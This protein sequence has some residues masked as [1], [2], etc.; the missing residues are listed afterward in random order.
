M[1]YLM[2]MVYM[3]VVCT[4]YDAE[5]VQLHKNIVKLKDVRQIVNF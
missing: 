4:Q 5:Y 2:A 1:V 3:T